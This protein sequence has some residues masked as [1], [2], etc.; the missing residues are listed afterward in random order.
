M[1]IRVDDFP[2]K[3]VIKFGSLKKEAKQ[4]QQQNRVHSPLLPW[5]TVQV[6]IEDPQLAVLLVTNFR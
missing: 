5:G 1:E 4:K 6:Q 3:G 2:I